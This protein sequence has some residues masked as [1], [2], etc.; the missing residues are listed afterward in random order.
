MYTQEKFDQ[1]LLEARNVQNPQPEAVETF[2]DFAHRFV[3]ALNERNTFYKQRIQ[4]ES[5]TVKEIQAELEQSL[6]N[7]NHLGNEMTAVTSAAHHKIALLRFQSIVQRVIKQGIKQ[8]HARQ[9]DELDEQIIELTLNNAKL[10]S[11]LAKELAEQNSRLANEVDT[12][13]AVFQR[14]KGTLNAARERNEI[15]ITELT[16]KLERV[17]ASEEQITQQNNI[18]LSQ[19][20]AMKDQ[21]SVF[22]PVYWDKV[23]WYSFAIGVAVGE[24]AI[25]QC[26]DYKPIRRLVSRG[27]KKL[28]GK[29]DSQKKLIPESFKPGMTPEYEAHVSVPIVP[30]V[31]VHN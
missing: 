23:S 20:S 3:F 30:V 28:F 21:H 26:T 25:E 15:Q 27:A 8:K 9:K 22:N 6:T 24:Q 17:L 18:L 14:E 10:T 12:V 7:I 1:L 31:Q 13:R 16:A 4:A 29:S 2:F 5:Q 11:D 19:M